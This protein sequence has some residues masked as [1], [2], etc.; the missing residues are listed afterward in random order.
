M[1]P[2]TYFRNYPSV[3]KSVA[4]DEKRKQIRVQKHQ[5]YLARMESQRKF[6]EERE[7]KRKRKL[8]EDAENK[9]YKRKRVRKQ[10]NVTKGKI[11]LF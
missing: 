5:N 9:S 10:R 3:D 2:N 8:E 4:A 6:E 1:L 11:I 7:E